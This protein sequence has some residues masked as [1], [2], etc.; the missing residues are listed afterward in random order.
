MKLCERCEDKLATRYM[1]QNLPI[2]LVHVCESCVKDKNLCHTA[3]ELML[4]MVT[5]ALA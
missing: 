2:R 5:K 4:R 1:W 3:E